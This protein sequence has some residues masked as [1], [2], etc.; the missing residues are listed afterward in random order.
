MLRLT[1][2][3]EAIEFFIVAFTMPIIAFV[4][5][6][7]LLAVFLIVFLAVLLGTRLVMRHIYITAI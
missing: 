4:S 3:I 1:I 7:L 5:L 2:N 6:V